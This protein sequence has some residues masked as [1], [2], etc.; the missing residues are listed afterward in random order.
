[1]FD[2]LKG[3]LPPTSGSNSF[4]RV[5]AQNW[6][7]NFILFLSPLAIM[8]L[9]SV[10]AAFQSNSVALSNFVP[11]ELLRGGMILYVLNAALDFFRK[12]RA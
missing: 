2:F 5:D 11:N 8:Y 7:H 9:V 6:V 10:I 1:M 3:G 12:Y 4:N